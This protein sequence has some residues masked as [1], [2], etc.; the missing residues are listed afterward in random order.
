[1]SKHPLEKWGSLMGGKNTRWIV[2]GLWIVFAV[3]LALVFPQ[4][5]SVENYAG[6]EIS[7][8]YTSVQAGKI[9]EEQF[10]ADSGIPLLITWYKEAGLT[11]EDLTNIQQ[12]CKNKT[13]KKKQEQSYVSYK[14]ATN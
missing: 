7:E 14:K 8:T 1:M 6:E 2:L 9:I 4:I 13:V 3:V 10:S 12:L 11:E 5:N